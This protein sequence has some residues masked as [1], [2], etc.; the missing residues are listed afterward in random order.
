[1]VFD[2]W[3]NKIFDSGED[4]VGWDGKNNLKYMGAGVYIWKVSLFDYFGKPH[5]YTGQVTIY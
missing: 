3:G 4:Y 5:I 1:M 2:R